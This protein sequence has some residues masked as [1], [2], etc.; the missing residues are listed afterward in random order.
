MLPGEPRQIDIERWPR[1]EAYELFRGFGFPFFSLTAEVDVAPLR[2]AC[3]EREVSFTVGLV[4]VLSRSA[5]EIPALRQRLRGEGV[6]EHDAV[7]PSITIL[8]DEETFR[9]VTLRYDPCFSRF[10]KE[11]AEKIA[12]GRKGGSL[13]MEID[14]DD[15]LFMTA[16]PWVSFTSMLH[17]AT[18]DPG[19]SVPRFAWGKYRIVGDSAPM[20][21][22]VQ[23]HHSL[24]DGIH[25]GRFFERTQALLTDAGALLDTAY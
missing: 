9:F 7:H 21:L 24:V 23:A 25:V 10:S 16:L 4:Y 18:L 14:R 22:N 13:W 20:P 8:S 3:H 1:R 12:A 2:C 5:N 6:V 11:A 15:F 17:P 19:D